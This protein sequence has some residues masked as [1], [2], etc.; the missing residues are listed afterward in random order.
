MLPPDMAIG[1]TS[2]ASARRSWT[3][4][5]TSGIRRAG[6]RL[7]GKRGLSPQTVK[8]HHTLLSRA[9]NLAVKWKMLSRS[10][11]DRVEAPRVPRRNL[12]AFRAE[13]VIKLMKEAE[14]TQ[15]QTNILLVVYTGLRRSEILGLRWRDVNLETGVLSVNQ[16]LIWLAD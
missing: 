1:R 11:M 8:H 12:P 6:G 7:D 16:T 15:Y 10:P 5:A 13:D 9:L 14:G 2:D 4:P 3:T